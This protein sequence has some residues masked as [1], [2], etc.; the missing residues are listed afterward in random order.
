MTGFA[1]AAVPRMSFA[2]A[3]PQTAAR[4]ITIAK[5]SCGFEREP[6]VRPF[7]FKGGYLTEE[8][9]VSAYVRSTSGY[10]RPRTRRNERPHELPQLGDDAQGSRL[11]RR[12]LDSH[13][14][15][16][17]RVRRGL[18]H[19]IRRHLRADAE[20]REDVRRTSDLRLPTPSCPTSSV[21]KS[22]VGS[23]KS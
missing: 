16:R 13:G 4:P 1:A 7:G 19:E 11:P 23:P 6:M 22:D 8:W 21:L 10:R 2:A 12:A 17:L 5:T 15:G 3:S 9:I 20:I 18:V 14:E